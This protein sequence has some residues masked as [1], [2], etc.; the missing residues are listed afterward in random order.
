MAL[1]YKLRSL[2]IQRHRFFSTSDPSDKSR[3][4]LSLIRFEQ[5]PERI[6]H[7]CRS[8]PLTPES[9]LDRL[10]F[11]KAVSNLR[12]SNH[13]ESIRTLVKDSMNQLNCNSERFISHFIILYGQGGLIQDAINLFDEMSEKGIDRNIKTLNSLLFSCLLG[14]E[15]IEMKRIFTEFPRKYG[16]DP[17]LDTYNTV[18]K[19]FSNSGYAS[20]AHSIF[21]EMEGKD[22]KPNATTFA[23]AIAGFYREQNYGGVGKM[24]NLMKKYRMEPGISIYN[25][26][27]QSLCKLGRSVEAKALF[28]GILSKGMKP[29]RAT[30]GHLVY[31]FCREGRLDVAKGLFE[32][33]VADRGLEPQAECYFT[34]VYYLCLGREFEVALGICKECMEKG[35]VPNITSMKL[36][37]DGLVSIGKI[38]EAKEIIG[39]VK[40]KFWR[41]AD[42]WSEIEMGLL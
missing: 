25:V 12:Q 6:L 1:P 33:M 4:A 30:Y 39:Y 28:D 29:N 42:S 41:N 26:R 31:G 35:W 14:R 36:L 11:S 24:I 13:H 5:N 34:M 21:A 27:I 2:L 22:I 23:N 16:L 3:V 15:Y 40:N 32:E 9:H 37:V 10:V 8:T 17:N 20:E 19:G 18:L 7:I 38:S